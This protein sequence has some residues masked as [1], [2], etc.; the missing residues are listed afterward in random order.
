[1]RPGIGAG[2]MRMQKHSPFVRLI[3]WLDG[4]HSHSIASMIPGTARP[5]TER[6]KSARI[7]GYD[8][9]SYAMADSPLRVRITNIM[10]MSRTGLKFRASH[11]MRP[12]SLLKMVINIAE[13]NRQIHVTA[14]V[15]WCQVTVLSGLRF[16]A[17]VIFVDIDNNDYNYLHQFVAGRRRRPHASSHA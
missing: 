4:S 17:G 6:R 3:G 15:M 12:N 2:K 16:R 1:M 9:V 10:N 14:K 11:R 7:R 8:L 5:R 13:G